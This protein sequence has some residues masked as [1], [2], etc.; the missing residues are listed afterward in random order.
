MAAFL[1]ELAEEKEDREVRV[2]RAS[3]NYIRRILI[4]YPGD[5]FPV[6]HPQ[7]KQHSQLI[8][9]LTPREM[10]VLRLLEEGLS[11]R[12]IADR[13]Y[14]SPNT[15]RVYTTNLYTKLDVHNR[16]QAVIRARALEII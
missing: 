2:N 9:S 7:A 3:R 4:A 8:E 12:E 14:L 11:N 15:L 5:I 10:D 13:L 6:S 16:T 1:R